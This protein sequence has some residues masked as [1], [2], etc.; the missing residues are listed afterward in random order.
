MVFERDGYMCQDCGRE[1][2]HRRRNELGRFESVGAVKVEADH[3][4]E[5]VDGGDA[6]G[7]ENLQTLCKKCHK[8]KT[9]ESRRARAL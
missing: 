4:F 9:A 1:G 8:A 2:Y 7:I 6:W 3:I 5:I